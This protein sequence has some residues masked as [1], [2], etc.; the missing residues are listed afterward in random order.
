MGFRGIL[1]QNA[2]NA[3]VS[4]NT[5]TGVTTSSTSTASG[6]SVTGTISGGSILGNII[7]D[8][9]NTNTGGYGS[10]GL[11][12]AATSTT[13][14]LTV[15][16]NVIYDVASYGFEDVT[17]IDNG[18][19]IMIDSGGGY[20]VFFNSVR[21][22]TNQT[23]SFGIPAAI[24]IGSGVTTTNTIDM[25]DNI[26]ATSQTVG[27][28]YAIWSSAASTVYTNINF[29]DYYPGTSGILGNIGGIDETTITSWRTGTGKD[30]NSIS[31]DPQ[32]NSTTNLQPQLGAP[33]LAQ[34]SLPAVSR[35]IFSVSPAVRRRRAWAPTR[36]GL[37][38]LARSSFTHH[39]LILRPR[40]ARVT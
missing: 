5:I 29:N 7:S 18:Y 11:Y 39:W 31:T 27:T 28:S 33:V 13:S 8:I 36:T 25:R 14:N 19:G 21:M 37:I 22:T 4:A 26:F 9:K 10:N 38:R 40:P 15:A 12:L 16:N 24:N 3:S 34:A 6:I 1:I 30:V 17:S 20:K 35:P 23:D 2:Q 32:F